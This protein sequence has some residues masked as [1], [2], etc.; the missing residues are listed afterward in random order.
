MQKM[1]A[2]DEVFLSNGIPVILQ[3]Y[4]GPV[5]ATYWWVRT[6]SADESAKEAGFAHFLEHML[7]KDAA[8]KETGRASTGKMAKTIESLGGDIN[9]YTSFDQTVYHVTCAA[10]H[11]ERV[12]D[13]FGTMAKPQRFLKADFEREREVILEELKKNEDSPGRQL[14]QTLFSTTFKKHPYGRPVIGFTKTLNAAK[15]SDLEGFYRRN[16][17]SGNMG[18][19]LVGP[20]ADKTGARR[21]AILRL[22]EKRFGAGALPKRPPSVRS[23]TSEPPIRSGSPLVQKKSFD[24]K[25]PMLSLAFRVPDLSHEDIPALDMIAGILGMGELSRLYQKLF[26][27]TSLATDVSAGLYVPKDPGMLYLEV[28]VDSV[29]KVNVAAAEVFKEI[30]RLRDEGPTPEELSRLIVNIE[31]E[32]LYAT[33]TADGMASRL[34]FLKF[35]MNDLDFDRKYLEQIHAVDSAKI[36][37]VVGRYLIPARMSGAVMVPKADGSFETAEISESVIELLSAEVH[38]GKTILK[39]S[40]ARGTEHPVEVIK[41]P[42]GVRVVYFERPQS[43]VFSVHASVMGGLRLELAQPIDAADRDWGSSY[44]MALTWS[45][46][47]SRSDARAIA[48]AVEGHAAG[49][50]GFSGRNTAGLQMTGLS[51]DWGNLSE[52]FTEVLVDPVFPEREVDHSRRVAEDAVRGIEEHTSQLCSKLFLETLFEKHPYGKMTTGSFES[53]KNIDSRKLQAFHRSWVRPERLVL[54][55]SGSIKRPAL[56]LWLDELDKKMREYSMKLNA[57]DLP[58]ALADEES[59][60]APRWVEKN[61]GREQTHIL[62]GGLGTRITADDRHALRLM[63]TILGGQSGRLFIELREKKSL[64]YTVAPVSFEGIE[65]GYAGTYIACSP[66]KR[67]EAIAG[68][69]AVLENL[70]EKG[71]TASEMSRAKEFFLGRRA[72]DLQSDSAL[73]AHYG[74]ETLYGIPLMPDEA[75]ASTIQAVSAKDI[76]EVCRKYLVTPHMVTSVVG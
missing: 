34:G 50:D 76:K 36:R 30:R 45:K 33:Q 19:V 58:V 13:A 55:I 49:L 54:A 72:M 73:A 40:P 12:V 32:R 53:L 24:V 8:A 47:T 52:V 59:L 43:H 5:A 62:V 39:K 44:M 51:R 74:L 10:Q 1:I 61:L 11:W 21:K 42:S 25:T 9:A 3:P 37:E 4:E 20:L 38:A 6:G 63:Q 26:D 22:L 15:V 41:L 56:D 71:P 69:R 65:R 2:P 29:S 67:E 75:F 28:E 31:S 18:L 7:F 57:R 23:R 64:A 70:A 16:Y 17:L 68:I 14:F 46:G 48:H 27:Q 66:S 35:I 60:K